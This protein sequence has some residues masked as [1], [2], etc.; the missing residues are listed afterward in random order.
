MDKL[1]QFAIDEYADNHHA[2]HVDE[3]I[4]A[5]RLAACDEC[6]AREGTACTA[7]QRQLTNF[8]KSPD[9]P[10][11]YNRW[12]LPKSLEVENELV[13]NV[14]ENQ[15]DEA[16]AGDISLLGRLTDENGGSVGD[17]DRTA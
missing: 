8:A 7:A 3:T 13:A 17:L 12:K 10:C 14:V 11:A 4:F 1:L 9:A 16:G 5:E 15:A 2:A 6:P